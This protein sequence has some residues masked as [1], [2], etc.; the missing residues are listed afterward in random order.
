MSE[1][2]VLI[3]AKISEE[4]VESGSE[5]DESDLEVKSRAIDKA[6]AKAEEEAEEELKLNIKEESDEFRLPT[7]EVPFFF[8][9]VLVIP[10]ISIM[11][12]MLYGH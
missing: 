6:R 2:V 5:S 1:G 4:G 9:N 8:F 3:L 10:F 11:C 7:K 12:S